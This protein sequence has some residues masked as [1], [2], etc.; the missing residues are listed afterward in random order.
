MSVFWLVAPWSLLEVCW[1]LRGIC[2][3]HHRGDSLS[4]ASGLRDDGGCK[5]LWNVGKLQGN[6]AQPP[7]RQDRPLAAVRTWSSTRYW[8]FAIQHCTNMFVHSKLSQ[9]SK[10]YWNKRNLAL[11][12]DVIDLS[13][14]IWRTKRKILPSPQ[15]TRSRPIELLFKK[16]E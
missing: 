7:R 10:W 14:Y 12:H 15:A 8:T 4:R 5:H 1:P 16:G 2:F 9:F 13:K 11:K 6:M 3:L